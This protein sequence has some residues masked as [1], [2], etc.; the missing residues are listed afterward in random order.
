MRYS[1]LL[2][3]STIMAAGSTYAAGPNINVSGKILPPACSASMAGGDNLVW[4]PISHNTLSDSDFTLLEAKEATLQVHCDDGLSTHIAFWATD[5]NKDSAIPGRRAPAT[6]NLPNG[7][8]AD[9]IFGIG[10]DPVETKNKIGNFTLIGKS[11]SY[12]GTVNSITYGY[13]NSKSSNL[14]AQALFG[15]G[16]NFS[17]EWTVVQEGTN[18]PAAAN[19]FTFTFDVVPQINRK[20]LITNS[21]TVDFAGSAQFFIRYF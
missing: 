16:Y 1:K 15:H 14:F 5:A 12:D 2:L 18:I 6:N 10:F 4:D 3:V 11:S 9:R 13:N 19:M 17:E 8:A 21:Q 7:D 20:P